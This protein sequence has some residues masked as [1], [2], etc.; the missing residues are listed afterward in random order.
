MWEL[1]KAMVKI[2]SANFLLIYL[3][4]LAHSYAL[5]DAPISLG[6]AI[7]IL[8]TDIYMF[9]LLWPDIEG[10]I[11]EL[12]IL[13]GQRLFFFDMIVMGVNNNVVI[14]FIRN[15]FRIMMRLLMP[16]I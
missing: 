14:V 8:L 9:V 10:D 6:L 7:C 15:Y 13:L 5:L 2:I 16:H 12:A 11:E 4:F 1:L 3:T